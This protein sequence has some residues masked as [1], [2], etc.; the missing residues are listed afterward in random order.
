MKC[1]IVFLI[2]ITGIIATSCNSG[3]QKNANNAKTDTLI[4]KISAKDT[5]SVKDGQI[6]IFYNM[7][8]SVEMSSL[9]KSIGA[10]YN[11]NLLNSSEK[12]EKYNSSTDKAMN[13]GVY[14]VDLS[15]CKYFEQFEQASGI[16]Q[17]HAKTIY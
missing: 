17:R 14:A 5:S 13:L 6:Q 7:Y 15:Y 10:V 9:F 3:K 8:L 1:N 2:V 4:S 12:V 11:Y 16:P